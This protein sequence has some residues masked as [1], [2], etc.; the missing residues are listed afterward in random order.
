MKLSYSINA[1]CEATSYSRSYIYSEIKGG[2][3]KAYKRGKRTFIL[4]EELERHVR[5]QAGQ[6]EEGGC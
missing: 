3:L 5:H 4:G 2:R 6:A 1:A